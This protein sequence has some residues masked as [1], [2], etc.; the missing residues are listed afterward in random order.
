MKK[1]LTA[2]TLGM[3]LSL[4]ANAD[5]IGIY[6][7]AGTISYDLSADF[8]DLTGGATQID[9]ENDLGLKGDS[10][11]YFYVA[12]EHPIP[13]LP[14]VKISHSDISESGTTTLNREIVFDG[15]TFPAG[16]EVVSTAD[17]THNDFTFYYEF[18]DNW[19]NLD[20]GVTAR[21]FDG[22]IS[23]QASLQGNTVTATQPL[24]F[25]AP[26]LYGMAQF[27]L[28]FTGLYV[29]ASGNWV[30]FGGAQLMDLWA[31]LGYEFSFGLGVEAGFRKLTAELDDV[32][33][34]DAD[35]TLDGTYLAATFHF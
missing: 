25:V 22:E 34:T 11:N 14:N 28:P 9:L 20:L 10:G 5:F 31:K 21:Q 3:C 35:I 19:V 27:D 1:T 6:A 23:G 30:G 33:D 18:L 15:K 12:F 24:D 4:H 29:Q 7:G 13:F 17:F 32:D 8:T 26:M 16:A 2:L